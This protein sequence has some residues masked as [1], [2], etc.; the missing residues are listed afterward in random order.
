MQATMEYLDAHRD[1][2]LEELK[3]F[4]RIPSVSTDPDRKADVR[5]AAEWT[6]AR[7]REAG[8]G[9]VQLFPTEGHPAVY[10]E[11][12][13]AP[14]RPTVLVYGHYDVQPPDPI[15]LWTTPPFE[16]SVRDGR[17]YARGAADDKGQVFTH[18]G[19]VQ[20]HMRVAGRLPVNV[21]FLIEGE[22]E[23]GSPH[24]D[25]FVGGH[26]D[27]LR[28]DVVAISDT[29]MIAKGH[30]S[31]THGLRG[32]LYYQVDLVGTNRDLHSGTYGGAVANPATVLCQLL[33]GMK[34]RNGRVTIPG[35]YDDVRRLAPAERR[36]LAR[37]PF[38]EREFQR[39]LD[40][41]ALAGEKGFTVLERLWCRPTFEVN[42]LQSGFTGAGSKTVIAA[43]AM[44]KVSMR[45]VPNQ[46]PE[47]VSRLFERH[48]ARRCPPTAR[49]ALTRLAAGR[50]WLTPTDHPAIRAGARAL[51]KGFGKKAVFIRSGGSIPVVA[52]FAR[53]LK[54]P[55][56][57]LGFGL[58]DENAHAP[59][60]NFDLDNFHGGLRSAAFLYEELASLS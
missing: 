29:A 26:R 3:E 21:K 38:R 44:A 19:A 43:A 9:R 34:D 30:P 49:L 48:M 4:L 55:C 2:C 53:V 27:L 10:G 31:I 32:L 46:D 60:E 7:L 8:C 22:E 5:R 59:D 47:K 33:A 41:P 45:L 37:L 39:R 13:G 52:T 28:C 56:V 57:L 24:L 12:L 51:Q 54:A 40:A 18:I 20:A 58:P 36:A 50:P 11:W 6:A 14:G 1:Q 17:L 25:A 16:P 42:G 15:P 35:F 23:I